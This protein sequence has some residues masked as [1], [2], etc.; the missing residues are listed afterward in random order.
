[1]KRESSNDNSHKSSAQAEEPKPTTNK[2]LMRLRENFSCQCL[3]RLS[4]NMTFLSSKRTH[5]IDWRSVSWTRQVR[6]WSTP[7]RCARSKR[8][9]YP[10]VLD[11]TDCKEA[12]VI[13]DLMYRP[14]LAEKYSGP[15]SGSNCLEDG[16]WSRWIYL[17]IT[18]DYGARS[19]KWSR[20]RTQ[21]KAEA[22]AKK[23]TEAGSSVRRTD[24]CAQI[25]TILKDCGIDRAAWHG[26]TSLVTTVGC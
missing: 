22:I 1:V 21:Q 17:E 19:R 15:E 16:R 6:S 3:S 25:E 26:V 14:T 18:S 13:W 9:V 4:S 7:A 20:W 5:L 24:G 12:S 11:K 8:R 2:R 23:L 10:G